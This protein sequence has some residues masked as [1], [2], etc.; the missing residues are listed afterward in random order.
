MRKTITSSVF[1][2]LFPQLA[3]A[4]GATTGIFQATTDGRFITANPA[5]AHILGYG[6]VRE[7]V[8]TVTNLARKR[9]DMSRNIDLVLTDRFF[10]LPVFVFFYVCKQNLCG[11]PKD[12]NCLA[13][14]PSPD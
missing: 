13:K 3:S 5:L 1:V 14:V 12:Y 7:L 2:L 10:G 6:S 9:I 4:P 11:R 8:E